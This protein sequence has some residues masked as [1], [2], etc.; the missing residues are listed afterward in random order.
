MQILIVMDFLK[1]L[2]K[3]KVFVS[4][5]TIFIVIKLLVFFTGFGA[6]AFIPE[7][8]TNRKDVTDNI[9]L[10]PWAQYDA[11]IYLDIAQNGYRDDMTIGVA[12]TNYHFYPLY[13]LL[14]YLLGF[15]TLPLAA[16]LVSNLASLGAVI[17]LYLIVRDEFDKKTAKRSVIYLL[18][19]PTAYYFTAMYTEAVFLFVSLATFYFAKK[20]NWLLTGMFG[21]LTA[22]TRPTGGILFFPILY[23]YLRS[24]KFS[25]KKLNLK[26]LR[27]DVLYML[28]IPIG[29][30]AF[31]FYH[32]IAVGNPF[33]QFE[34]FKL[35]PTEFGFPW[36]GYSFAVSSIFTDHTLIN[37]SYH[38]FNL[39]L[40]V[41]LVVGIY[42]S[43]K[44]LKKEYVMY[45][46]LGLI[47]IFASTTLFGLPRYSLVL[48]PLFMTFSV[49]SQKG[50]W[51]N[52]LVILMYVLFVILLPVLIVLHANER[53][54]TGLVFL[55]LF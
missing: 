8:I 12:G 44:Y 42:F 30:F 4:V 49:F 39:F 52:K 22:I 34:S 46:V 41:V 20:E 15:M 48:F 17:L 29:F 50:K 23:M 43:W 31:M 21:F 32:W 36:E 40:S 33:A 27:P 14:I 25:Y 26:V 24:K 35:W 47:P 28:L 13:P 18:L 54:V 45:Y 53:F 2:S 37:V 16:F 5:L 6:Q 7:E 3:D 51:N 38:V 55:E 19:F 11:R 1:N 10:N 9:F